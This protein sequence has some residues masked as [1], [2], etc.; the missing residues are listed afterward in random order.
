MFF[1]L[2][3]RGVAGS[4]LRCCGTCAEKPLAPVSSGAWV[5]TSMWGAELL[6]GGYTLVFWGMFWGCFGVGTRR[7]LGFWWNLNETMKHDRFVLDLR[8]SDSASDSF[9]QL[10]NKVALVRCL[11]YRFAR[12]LCSPWLVLQYIITIICV[13][14]EASE[15]SNYW[16]LILICCCNAA[17]EEWSCHCALQGAWFQDS[18]PLVLGRGGR[19]DRMKWGS[20][21]AFFLGNDWL[22]SFLAISNSMKFWSHGTC[23]WETRLLGFGAFECSVR[24]ECTKL[25]YYHRSVWVPRRKVHKKS[26]KSFLEQSQQSLFTYKNALNTYMNAKP[27]LLLVD[28]W[29]LNGKNFNPW[30]LEVGWFRWFA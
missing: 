24:T 25:N 13:G 19:C 6:G 10:T 15:A 14:P 21:Q 4:A 8:A 22:A 23:T 9:I 3:V 18:W 5:C 29:W 27:K 2:G 17:R 12:E 1:A 28:L 7:V 11:S 20:W 30:L 16:Q 26:R